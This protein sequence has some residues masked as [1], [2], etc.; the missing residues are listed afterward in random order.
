MEEGDKKEG[1][2]KRLRNIEDKNKEQSK[3]ELRIIKN[4]L[5]NENENAFKRLNF[6]NKLGP[7]SRKILL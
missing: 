7:D 1:L 3:N 2:L 4:G 6:I 5:N